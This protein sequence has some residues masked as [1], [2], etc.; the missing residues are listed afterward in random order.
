MGGGTLDASENIKVIATVERYDPATDQW[1]KGADLLQPRGDLTMVA[2]NS[3]LY[4][5]GGVEGAALKPVAT[6]EEFDPGTAK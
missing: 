1:T 6:V 3:K 5:I 4:A 2:V